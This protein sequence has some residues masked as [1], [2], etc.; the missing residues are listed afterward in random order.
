MTILRHPT[1]RLVSTY[2][3]LLS[4]SGAAYRRFPAN[5]TFSEFLGFRRR[6]TCAVGLGAACASPAF[7]SPSR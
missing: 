6:G 1:A 4:P 7:S 5:T 2:N 3:Y